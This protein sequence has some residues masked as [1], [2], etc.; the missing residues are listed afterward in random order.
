M[1]HTC[2]S[3]RHILMSMQHRVKYCTRQKVK[4]YGWPYKTI[5]ANDP[6]CGEYASWWQMVKARNG[7][8]PIR[9]DDIE[10][11]E[12]QERHYDQLELRDAG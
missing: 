7:Q 10:M 8:W 9:W 12:I 5:S 4:I 6:A 2:A 11:P 1:G 3:C